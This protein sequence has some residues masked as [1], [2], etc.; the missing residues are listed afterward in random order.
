MAMVKSN[1]T[2][3]EKYKITE[4]IPMIEA[5]CR[6]GATDLIIAKKLHMGKTTF[7]KLKRESPELCELLKRDKDYYDDLVENALHKST[8]GF[9]YEETTQERR[10][11]VDGTTT[12]IL[13]RKIKKF[14]PPSI[15]AQIYWTKNRRP[16][17]W[18]DK[19]VI[20][21]EGNAFMEAILNAGKKT[22]NDNQG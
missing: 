15:I 12:P 14:I 4:K 5:W 22:T 10:V 11:N 16:E 1:M 7:Y 2:L 17:T 8:L 18:R 6:N 13:I 21:H 20:E 3:Y 19:Q 9:E